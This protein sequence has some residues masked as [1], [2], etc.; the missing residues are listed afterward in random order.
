MDYAEGFDLLNYA[1]KSIRNDK[2]FFRWTV[3]Y[4]K[5]GMSYE[6]FKEKVISKFNS[7]NVNLSDKEI[8][9]NIKNIMK[10]YNK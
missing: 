8:L 1:I 4:E 6:E 3:N 7:T 10:K 9:N 5:I 2:L